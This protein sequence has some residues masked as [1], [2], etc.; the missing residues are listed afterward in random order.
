MK[1]VVTRVPADSCEVEFGEGK[2]VCSVR[3]RYKTVLGDWIVFELDA[4]NRVVAIELVG[5]KPC[6]M[7]VE[8]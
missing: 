3:C 7:G 6:Q 1:C 8:E 5:D 2:P 4:L